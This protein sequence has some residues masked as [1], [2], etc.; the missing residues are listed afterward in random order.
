MAAFHGVGINFGVN[1]TII[2]VNGL[3]QSR[4]HSYKTESELIRDGGNTTVSKVF[5]DRHEVAT[6]TYVSY[7]PGTYTLG[8]AIVDVPTLG[9]WVQIIDNYYPIFAGRWMVD[10]IE[11]ASSNQGAAKVTLQLSRYPYVSLF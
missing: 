10:D 3:F 9:S 2:G 5:Y 4:G 8:N 1:S 11:V 6:V 7:Q